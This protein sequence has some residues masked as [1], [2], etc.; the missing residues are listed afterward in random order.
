M[1]KLFLDQIWAKWAK[2][3]PRIRM[4][5]WH[6]FKFVLLVFQEIVLDDSQE[7]FLTTSRGK[8]HE[9][10]LGRPKLGPKLGFFSFSQG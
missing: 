7:H 8:T 10:I 4:V 2:I 1:K 3:G 5:F 9:K 6:F